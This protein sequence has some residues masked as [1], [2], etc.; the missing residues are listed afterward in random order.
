MPGSGEL[1][2]GT[3]DSGE[4]STAGLRLLGSPGGSPGGVGVA[5]ASPGFPD[6]AGVVGGEGSRQ[7]P[8]EVR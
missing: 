6:I 5:G 2:A 1:E 3:L 4:D 7:R 8:V